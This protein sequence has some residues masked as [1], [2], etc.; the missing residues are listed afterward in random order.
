VLLSHGH[1]QV[2]IIEDVN[3]LAAKLVVL[4]QTFPN[5]NVLRVRGPQHVLG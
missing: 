2:I 1:P 4:K 5:T 3:A